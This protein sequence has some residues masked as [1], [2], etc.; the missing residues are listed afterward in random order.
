MQA[1]YNNI[2]TL[3]VNLLKKNL[4]LAKFWDPTDMDKKPVPFGFQPC[5]ELWEK[6]HLTNSDPDATAVGTLMVQVMYLPPAEASPGRSEL[7]LALDPVD[8]SGSGCDAFLAQKAGT[9]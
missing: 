2:E 3:A 1:S 6:Q 9:I 5:A 7:S 4:Q 8:I